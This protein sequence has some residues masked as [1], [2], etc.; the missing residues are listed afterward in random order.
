MVCWV[1]LAESFSIGNRNLTSLAALHYN[2]GLAAGGEP[3]CQP[4]RI[5]AAEPNGKIFQGVRIVQKGKFR[6][7][8]G[9]ST[10]IATVLNASGPRKTLYAVLLLAGVAALVYANSLPNGF[11]F[12]DNQLILD[13]PAIRNVGQYLN[14]LKWDAERPIPLPSDRGTTHRPV[15]AAVLALEYHFFGSNPLGYRTINILLHV[16]NG[17]LV[18]VILRSLLGG[19]RPALLAAL[20]FVVHPIQT[21]AV[22]YISG[23]RDLLFTA[24]YLAGFLCFV[25][26]RATQQGRW[27]AVAALAYLLG[28]FSKEMTITLPVLC[29]VY[30]LICHLP[31]RDPSVASP[32]TKSVWHALRGAIARDKWLYPTGAA[33]LTLALFYFVF[34][35]NPSHTRTLYGGGL[36]PTLNTSA[37]IIVLYL[38]QLVFPLTLNADYS[39]NAFPVSTSLGDPRGLLAGLLLAGTGYGLLR[40]LRRNRWAAFGGLWFFI[41]LLPVSQIIPHHELLAEHFLY[42][43]SIGFCMIAGYAVERGLTIRRY[44]VTVAAVSATVLAV[45]AV[46][47][48]VRNRDWADEL[49]L[50]TKTVQTAPQS[51]RARLNL[52]QSLKG[53]GRFQEAI[54]QFQA[55]SVIEPSSASGE[56]GMGD[57]YRLMGRYSDAVERFEKALELGPSSA[58][59]IVGLAQT[60]AAMGEVNKAAELSSRVLG[61]QFNNDQ[62]YRQLGDAYSGAGL[63]A[64]AVEAYKKGLELNPY[65]G[66]LHYALGKA[67]TALGQL[68]RAV[69]AYQEAVKLMPRSPTFRNSLAALYLETGQLEAATRT[70]QE[71]L[72]LDPDYA[73]AHNNLGIA[74][75]RL[76][77]TSEA[78][79]E[80]ERAVAL[81]PDSAEFQQNLALAEGGR[82]EPRLA[83]LER[84]VREAPT[85]AKA[86]YNL[87]TAYA[88]QGDLTRAGRE[89]QQALRLDSGNPLIH[90]ALGLLH[91]QRGEPGPAQQAWERAL[92]L[93]PSFA[94]ARERLAELQRGVGARRVQ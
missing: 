64:Q 52:A 38:K 37:R 83:E 20:L 80:F 46:R 41:T 87:G 92:K 26:F 45:L 60:Y 11:V 88:N 84:A 28:L 12:D 23:Q 3:A 39:H 76:G 7:G 89:F 56:I 69:A 70:L 22:A 34:V 75:H 63:H 18:F 31:G 48:V 90:Y 78:K 61:A 15:R 33:L 54:E 79:A 50:W 51:S 43:P 17:A 21:D 14:I 94:L 82:F 53:K 59:P 49:T 4:A 44:A 93:D 67:Y 55:Y 73:E 16:L 72:Q 29:A 74:Y 86:H 5:I 30:D 6:S 25:R 40:L 77:R 42:L 65:N 35:A 19:P 32:L 85:S 8:E 9:D 47:T 62:S 2:V 66:P 1:N 58:T 10:R 27:L 91:A 13:N 68:E 71:A 81:Q 57:T 36:G 24:F